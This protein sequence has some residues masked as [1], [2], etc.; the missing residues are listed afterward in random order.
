MPK[1][2]LQHQLLQQTYVMLKNSP[3][4]GIGVFTIRD[5][6]KGCREIFSKGMG[7]WIKVPIAEVEI[8]PEH[9]RLLFKTYCLF[10][11][12]NYFVRNMVLKC[13]TWLFT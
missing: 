2:K 6:P 10:D 12:Q 1:E 7:E 8:L 11:E 3:V 4:H 5:I 13:R 9:S